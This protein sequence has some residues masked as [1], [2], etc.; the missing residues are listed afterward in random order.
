LSYIRKF[1]NVPTGALLSAGQYD[2]DLVRW[3]FVASFSTVKRYLKDIFSDSDINL[4][5]RVFENNT[6][7]KFWS[8]PENPVDVFNT[9]LR[10]S[11]SCLKAIMKNIIANNGVFRLPKVEKA[12]R[13]KTKCRT[14]VK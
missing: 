1:N 14:K 5:E 6:A 8:D 3:R 7:D 2:G 9:N 12:K 10:D 4:I 13:T 11:K